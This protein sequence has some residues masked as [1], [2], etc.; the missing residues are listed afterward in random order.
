MSKVASVL[1]APTDQVGVPSKSQ[2]TDKH[3]T[4]ARTDGRMDA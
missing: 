3:N 1:A 2:R 4:N